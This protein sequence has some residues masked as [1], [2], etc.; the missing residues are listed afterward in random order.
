MDILILISLIS[1]FLFSLSAAISAIRK[2]FDL[3]GIFFISFLSGTG[4]GILRDILL[5][6]YPIT[7]VQDPKFALATILASFTT[8]LF[9]IKKMKQFKAFIM[10]DSLGL[11]SATVLGVQKALNSDINPYMA[12]LFGVISACF[13]SVVRDLLCNETPLLFKEELYATVSIIG[14]IFYIIMIF[15]GLDIILASLLSVGIIFILRMVSVK[16]KLVLPK[17]R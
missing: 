16:Y 2:R 12:I 9:K 15:L 13:G 3:I 6:K 14:S 8:I 5:G 11:G 17:I 4:G 10:F 7:C 1:T